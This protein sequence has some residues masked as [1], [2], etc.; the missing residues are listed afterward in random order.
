MKVVMDSGFGYP[1]AYP[2]N[3]NITVFLTI[4][5]NRD[6]IILLSYDPDGSIPHEYRSPLRKI[7]RSEFHKLDTLTRKYVERVKTAI[8][9]GIWDTTAPRAL[10]WYS[11]STQKA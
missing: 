2:V 1:L 6:R 11:D 8:D 4:N 5:N 3:C 10:K 7:Y 9:V